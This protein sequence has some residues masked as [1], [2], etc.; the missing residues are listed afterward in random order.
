MEDKE[1]IRMLRSCYLYALY[2]ELCHNRGENEG[3]IMCSKIL[4]VYLQF[5]LILLYNYYLFLDIGTPFS[6]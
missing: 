5:F 3:K 1:I 4:Q 6:P 2:I